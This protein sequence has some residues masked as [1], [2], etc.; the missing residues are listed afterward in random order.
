MI[1]KSTICVNVIY[2]YVYG[3][4]GCWSCVAV[5]GAGM[6]VQLYNCNALIYV[7]DVLIALYIVMC[8]SIV[9][10]HMQI[11]VMQINVSV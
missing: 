10:G 7:C 5:A 4:C 1:Y 11:N 9:Y 8:I 6:C 2:V 3:V